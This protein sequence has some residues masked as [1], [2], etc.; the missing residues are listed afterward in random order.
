MDW[1][2][3]CSYKLCARE[4]RLKRRHL[5]SSES[6]VTR[7]IINGKHENK[8][9]LKKTLKNNGIKG[10]KIATTKTYQNKP[11]KFS[12]V[13][14]MKF[15]VEI[16]TM[17]AV[18]YVAYFYCWLLPWESQRPPTNQKHHFFSL[19]HRRNNN[20]K[21]KALKPFSSLPYDLP[22]FFLL[23]PSGKM[24]IYILFIFLLW[25]AFDV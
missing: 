1:A 13:F 2:I 14:A 19:V 11:H 23:L 7:A 9:I 6:D 16:K 25:T 15:C 12:F 18:L 21:H 5:E 8:W 24:S 4:C 17:K 10:K 20:E 22:F 3:I